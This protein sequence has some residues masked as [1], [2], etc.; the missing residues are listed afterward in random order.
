LLNHTEATIILILILLPA[1]VV[2]LSMAAYFGKI[3][4]IRILYRRNEI[5]GKENQS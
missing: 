5:N 1:Y 3:W 4:A 2:I